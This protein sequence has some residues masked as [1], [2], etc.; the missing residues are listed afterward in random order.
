MS[1]GD[2]GQGTGDWSPP[3]WVQY[4]KPRPV[5]AECSAATPYWETGP[6]VGGERCGRGVE[7]E[8]TEGTEEKEMEEMR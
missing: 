4:V 8:R 7:Q 3:Q 6:G 2:K 1:R 5:V